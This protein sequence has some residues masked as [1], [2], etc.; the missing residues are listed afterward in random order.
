MGSHGGNMRRAEQYMFRRREHPARG[1]FAGLLL[2]LAFGTALLYFKPDI[3][4][5]PTNGLRP[6]P[7]FTLP[8][9]APQGRVVMYSLSSCTVCAVMR[10]NLEDAHIA[11]TEYFIDKDPARKAELDQRLQKYKIANAKVGTPVLFIGDVLYI[12]RTP[13]EDIQRDLRHQS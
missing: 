10:F 6:A 9:T 2:L 11:Y 13:I 4:L 1:M 12:G 5:S 3:F 7:S 8:E